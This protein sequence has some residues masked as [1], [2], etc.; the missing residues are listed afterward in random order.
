MAIAQPEDGQNNSPSAPRIPTTEH[1]IP[2]PGFQYKTTPTLG[3]SPL[4]AILHAPFGWSVR[5]ALNE[6]RYGDLCWSPR[7]DKLL[8]PSGPEG[9]SGSSGLVCRGVAGTGC[10]QYL[11]F[12]LNRWPIRLMLGVYFPDCRRLYLRLCLRYGVRRIFSHKPQKDTH[13]Q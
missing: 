2:H 9:S 1:A 5:A 8:T 12:L 3:D 11:L 13:I 6:P 10:L 7:N 4:Y